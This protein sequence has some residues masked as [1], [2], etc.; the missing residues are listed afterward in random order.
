MLRSSLLTHRVSVEKGSAKVN[1]ILLAIGLLMIVMMG[2][3]PA[4]SESSDAVRVGANVKEASLAEVW[5]SVEKE[6]GIQDSTANLAEFVLWLSEDG[7]VDLLHYMFYAKD[8]DGGPGMYFVNSEHDGD[9]TYYCYPADYAG[10][11]TGTDPLAV[12]EEM[13][14]V[15]LATM[16]S[17]EASAHVGMDFMSGAVKY[18]GSTSINLYHLKDGELVPLEEVMFRTNVPW[19]VLRVSRWWPGTPASTEYWFLTSELGKAESVDY[20]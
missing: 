13:D 7:A 12:F 1:R 8:A 14:R 9:V 10:V 5:E 3:V 19:G 4:C 6:T 20:A 2:L 15:P 18:G 11:L 17:G 16:L